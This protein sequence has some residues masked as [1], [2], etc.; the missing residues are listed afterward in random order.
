MLMAATVSA[1]SQES[2]S[3]IELSDVQIEVPS[4]KTI[5]KKAI[6]NLKKLTKRSLDGSNGQWI[7]ITESNGST[8]QLSR[9]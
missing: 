1:I 8:V 2:E 3:V 9:E 4:N 6:G 5:I 7:Q